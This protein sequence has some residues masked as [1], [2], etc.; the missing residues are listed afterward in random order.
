MGAENMRRLEKLVLLRTIDELWM[1]H[2]EA[3]EY[4]RDSVRLR[5]YGQRDPLVEYKIEGQNMYNQL[6]ESIKG[7]VANL[8]FKVSFVEQP[9]AVKLEEK[10]PDIIGDSSGHTHQPV[11]NEPTH[12]DSEMNP[13]RSREGSQR[14]STSN[15]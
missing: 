7:Q 10:R 6:M 12:R 13:V 14:A 9:K 11:I 2:I 3:M 8:I 4:L 1:D 15:G 5:A